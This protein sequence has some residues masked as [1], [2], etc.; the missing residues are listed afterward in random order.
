MYTDLNIDEETNDNPL[1]FDAEEGYQRFLLRI[2]KGKSHPQ[3]RLRIGMSRWH[4]PQVAAAMI[5]FM[6]GVFAY[7][8]YNQSQLPEIAYYETIVPLGAKSQIV[9]TDGTQVWL[10]AGSKLRY[11]TAFASKNRD[12]FLEGEGYFEVA[13]NKDLP[14]EVKTSLLNVKA[15]GT[16]FNVKAY[17]SDSIVETT[18]VE[19]KIVVSGLEGQKY[20]NIELSPKQTL[21]LYKEGNR[22]AQS[23]RQAPELLTQETTQTPVKI[24]NAVIANEPDVNQVTA[25]K[26]NKLVF[27]KE[28]LGDVKIKMERWYGV[29]I[30]VRNPEVENYLFTGTFEKETFEQAMAAL[31]EAA[32]CTFRIDKNVAIVIKK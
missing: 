11:S 15:I 27:V 10:N 31:S 24:K 29:K 3:R 23:N 14:F 7:R 8:Y 9:L 18:L 30:E 19:G 13:H 5:L 6:L 32:S 25:W 16:S 28:R 2:Q 21:T 26:N 22:L 20:R 17:P 4:I 1:G 12:V